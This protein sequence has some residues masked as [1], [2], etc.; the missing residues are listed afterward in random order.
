MLV[1]LPCEGNWV[2][3]ADQPGAAVED[4]DLQ[5]CHP[6]CGPVDA[7]FSWRGVTATMAPGRGRSSLSSALVVLTSDVAGD[8]DTPVGEEPASASTRCRAVTKAV[9]STVRAGIT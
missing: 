8:S 3:A 1:L 7:R 2:A 6:T 4:Y 9:T 5:V